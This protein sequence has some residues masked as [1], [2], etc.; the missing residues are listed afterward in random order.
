MA[1][2]LSFARWCISGTWDRTWS[3]VCASELMIQL[4]MLNEDP[5]ILIWVPLFLPCS[6]LFILSKII[7]VK[8]KANRRI[9]GICTPGLGCSLWSAFA[10][11]QILMSVSSKVYALMVSVW[12]PWAATD[13]PAKWD[14]GPILP[15]QV[16]FVSNNQFDFLY[17]DP[18]S[19]GVIQKKKNV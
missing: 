10:F 9:S 16:V 19:V 15:F 1:L 8:Q 13:V 18:V 7:S 5:V 17:F 2:L 3:I 12:T 4:Q 14:L 6:P 11:L